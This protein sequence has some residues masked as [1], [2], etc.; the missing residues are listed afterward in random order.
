MI[1]NELTPEER[2]EMQKFLQEALDDAAGA[3]YDAEYGGA[4]PHA[5]Q[6]YV[7][8]VEKLLRYLAGMPTELAGEEIG[9]VT[10]R[11]PI[12]N[13]YD[14]GDWESGM[15][16]GYYADT[17]DA[18]ILTST[19]P[20]SFLPLLASDIY[21]GDFDSDQTF[22]SAMRKTFSME[23]YPIPDKPVTLTLFYPHVAIAPSAE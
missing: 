15:E 13:V 7:S 16:G 18:E 8:G 6:V 14:S 11:V 21:H 22:S 9:H 12:H 3:D 10:V 1:A 20:E 19:L 23:A 17:G 2:V 5:V 4:L